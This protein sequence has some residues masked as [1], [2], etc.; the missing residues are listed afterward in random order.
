[1]KRKFFAIALSLILVIS[2]AACSGNTPK[3]NENGGGNSGS[4]GEA[5]YGGE[6]TIGVTTDLDA[7]L[8]PHVSSSSAGTREVLF[9][10]FEG[11]VKPD[12][13]GN[14][15][16]AVAE[17]VSVNDTA[18]EYTFTLRKGVK[19]HNGN[20]VTSKDVVYSLS[21]AA[22]LT[23]GEPL[24]SDVAGIVAVE[25]DDAAGTVKVTLGAPDTEF[26][27]HV[28]TAIIPEDIDP[29]VEA[30]GTGPYKLAQRTVQE[31]IV[32]EKFEDYWGEPAYLDKVILKVIDNAETLV[33]SLKSGAV[34]MATHLVSSQV[35][36]L[37]DMNIL[38]GSS[39]AVQALYLNN[40]FEPFTDVKVRQALN[41]AIDQQAILD[42]A[43]DG[44]GSRVGSSMFP[45]FK[46][47]FMEEL[48]D[49]YP[50]DVEKAKAL[51]AEAGKENLEFTITV[52]SNMQQHVDTAQVIV[53][54]LKQAGINAK[55]N[56]V[57]WATWLEETYRGRQFEA[58]IV[59]FDAHG[60]AASDLLARFQSDNGKNMINFNSE[61]Y[62]AKYKEATSTTD[63][64]AQTAAF[65]ECEKILA[66][67]A[68]NVYI[69]DVASFVALAKGYEG[70]QFYPLYVCDFATIYKTA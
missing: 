46:K 55:I 36:E 42:I 13:E 23:T 43:F 3:D 47:Y 37:G 15:I 11:L 30:I 14:I 51:L 27:A 63:D 22:G 24:V 6:I 49:L 60:V 21:R 20:E 17:E 67:E 40:A 16:P 4:T 56:Q 65:K 7:S 48:N 5:T 54:Q 50:Y 59:S 38:E 41:Y 35:N 64:E 28:T 12:S 8:D 62:D 53:E 25:A 10:V 70:F 61:A 9:N 69:Q 39:N 33:M 57:E 34:Q 45:A 1:M 32:F 19:F 26:L 31:S 44:H 66:E 18:D 29:A 68:A 52:P 58:T 2:L